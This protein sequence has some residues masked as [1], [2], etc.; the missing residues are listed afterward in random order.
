[1]GD[2]KGQVGIIIIFT[3]ALLSLL[4]GAF[5]F[6]LF[7]GPTKQ[8][9]GE[10]GP[11]FDLGEVEGS[12]ISSYGETVYT[13]INTLSSSLSWLGGI[14]YII[15]LFGIIGLAFA[16]RTSGNGLFI[17]FFIVCL[18]LVIFV[19]IMISNAYEE[20]L[21]DDDLGLADQSL[22]SFLII[23]GPAIITLLGFIGGIIMFTGSGGLSSA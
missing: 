23:N 19:S 12:N 9:I 21:L 3:I 20:L 18:L 1:M 6:S 2:N 17:V 8:F 7:A 13:P 10:L 22:L 15:A 4:V 14:I 5:F 11:A 16:Y